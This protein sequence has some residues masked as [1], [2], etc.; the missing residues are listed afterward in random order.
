MSKL[1]V[2]SLMHLSNLS[3]N[4]STEN[5]A[6]SIFDSDDSAVA[7]AIPATHTETVK[8][9]NVELIPKPSAATLQKTNETA[10]L[11]K[12]E[13]AASAHTE[14]VK[15][16]QQKVTEAQ[17][18]PVT[19]VQPKPSVKSTP[20]AEAKDIQA[21]AKSTPTAEV[22]K[23]LPTNVDLT[24]E[25]Q[26]VDQD[27][28]LGDDLDES[29]EVNGKDDNLP[30]DD[31]NKD[32]GVSDNPNIDAYEDDT[33]QEVHLD[34]ANRNP[35]KEA[36]DVNENFDVVNHKKIEHVNFE[37]DPDSNFFTYLCAVMFLCVLLYILHQNRHKILA[38]LLEG[39]RGRRGRE[40]TRN[41][42]KAAY[43]KLDCNLEEAIT[44]KKSL[45]GKS[46]DVIY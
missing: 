4:I 37:E 33:D 30:I 38:L 25:E 29:Q 12:A 31:G 40:R 3:R 15:T 5:P 2:Q 26:A 27:I 39:R 36:A 41:G 28:D 6:K 17:L 42:S 34:N 43:S 19:D 35:Q 14:S 20:A 46:M 11:A 8:S 24:P 18:K 23:T 44:S 9:T 22:K 1:F 10:P 45:N 16:N 7:Q 21:I 13:S 32:I